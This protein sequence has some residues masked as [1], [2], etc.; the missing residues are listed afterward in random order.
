MKRRHKR[1]E[2]LLADGS[3]EFRHIFLILSF[4]LLVLFRGLRLHDRFE[5]EDNLSVDR[6]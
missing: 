4:V 5:L 1:D 6:Y 3:H 2:F